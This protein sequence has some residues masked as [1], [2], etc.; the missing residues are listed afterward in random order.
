MKRMIVMS[1]GHWAATVV[2]CKS[3][4]ILVMEVWG[5]MA[6]FLMELEITIP[7]EPCTQL[8]ENMMGST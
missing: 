3:N 5:I 4:I 2:A 8:S 7:S 6:E 1:G